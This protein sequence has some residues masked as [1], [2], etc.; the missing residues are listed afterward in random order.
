L[1]AGVEFIVLV[2]K[3][4]FQAGNLMISYLPHARYNG[5]KSDLHSKTYGIVSRSGAPRVN[6][7][8]MDA[9]RA[10]MCVP[11]ASPFVYYNLLTK[12]GTIGDFT[13]SVYSALRDVSGSSRVGVRVY[14]RFVDIDLQFP[15]GQ[16]M[17]SS[18][19]LAKVN[20]LTRQLNVGNI[21]AHLR[22]LN[23]LKDEITAMVRDFNTLTNHSNDTSI[24]SFKQK[25]LPN[26]TSS[27]GMN[28][29]HML[30]LSNNNSLN[31]M[32]MGHASQAEM[33]FQSITRIPTYYATVPLKNDVVAGT[34]LWRTTVTPYTRPNVTGVPPDTQVA[35]YLSFIAAPF[36][37]WRGPIIYHFR[38]VKTPYHSVRVRVGWSPASTANAT[39]DRNACYSKIVDLKDRNMFTLEVPYVYPQPWL[40]NGENGTSWCGIIFL[41]VEVQ[42][43]N[44]DVVAD[45]I[46]IIVE[47]SAGEGIEF[48]LPEVV[49]YFPIDS[50]STKPITPPTPDPPN[51][52]PIAAP[53][54]E[55]PP[56]NPYVYDSDS[57]S[58]HS[59]PDEPV[60]ER[61]LSF[62]NHLPQK[63]MRKVRKL[64]EAG[65]APKLA[66]MTILN[67]M[68]GVNMPID[69]SYLNMPF[70]EL[71]AMFENTSAEDAGTYTRMQL[72]DG[73]E[74]IMRKRRSA[75]ATIPKEISNLFNPKTQQNHSTSF[76]GCEKEDQ[77]LDRESEMDISFI[78]PPS[79]L[80]ADQYT[81]G[82][83]ISSVKQMI[84]RS[85]HI[86][87][88]GTPTETNPLHIQP[89]ALAPMA[90][91]TNAYVRPAMDNLSYYAA[92]YTFARGGIGMRIVTDADGYAVL[93]DPSGNLNR[94]K[95]TKMPPL[96]TVSAKWSDTDTLWSYNFITQAINP[97]VEGY[98]EFNVPFYST[99]YCYAYD[100]Q[101][102]QNLDAEI[103]NLQQPST[104]TVV[105]PFPGDTGNSVWTAYRHASHDYEFS[106]LSGPP[107]VGYV[108]AANT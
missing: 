23:S 16:A 90:Y 81:L 49:R 43:V 52:E 39:I 45:T 72:A 50:R 26:M 37:Q 47:R 12:E 5:F 102:T 48:N 76:P 107:L 84:M 69:L 75:D 74:Y 31:P 29:T 92:L 70:E 4:P 63:V 60:T 103:L 87:I 61:S 2:N 9:T 20:D 86:A 77:D 65:S 71:Q 53:V 1:R 73:N 36:R 95:G 79:A 62:F 104:H 25:A 101:A 78:R 22:E 85:T 68:A 97:S 38:V 40:T 24:T 44:S 8:L 10:T 14:A 30:S 93:V 83:S 89:H 13:I 46:D 94:P 6:L 18:G 28:E 41:D 66:I 82:S 67:D 54:A 59:I 11:Y 55:R 17:P 27:N 7:D 99:S 21:S 80:Q 98:G 32:N 33:S 15:T 64:I 96:A 42:M 56:F 35:D 108:F 91:V 100:M 106:V 58:G 57:T 88:T 51:P 3:Q 34:E 105:I 19:V